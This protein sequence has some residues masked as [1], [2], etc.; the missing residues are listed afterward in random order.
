M[1]EIK[2]HNLFRRQNGDVVLVDDA[3][4]L[5]DG[6]LVGL[7][8]ELLT[9]EPEEHVLLA[10]LGAKKLSERVP[11]CWAAHHLIKGLPPRVDLLQ[12]GLRTAK[13][14]ETQRNQNTGQTDFNTKTNELLMGE[15]RWWCWS[16]PVFTV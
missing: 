14:P 3:G 13:D 5:L 1:N 2:V 16:S 7:L 6:A 4:L 8:A 15:A 10:E 9:G 12:R 11:P